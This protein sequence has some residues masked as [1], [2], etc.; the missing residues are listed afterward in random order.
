VAKYAPIVLRTRMSDFGYW[1]VDV[2]MAP[3][4]TVSVMIAQV[5][6]SP[7]QAEAYA[8]ERLPDT[9]RSIPL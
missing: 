9:E 5:G 4:L 3:D 1:V 2:S 6:I 8:L 7:G